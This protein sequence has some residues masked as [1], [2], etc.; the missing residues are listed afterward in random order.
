ML[1]KREKKLMDAILHNSN[2]F[3]AHEKIESVLASCRTSEHV[4]SVVNM[5][6]TFD[7]RFGVSGNKVACGTLI[8]SLHRKIEKKRKVIVEAE[9]FDI[10]E[11]P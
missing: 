3:E 10:I 1:S 4:E 9:N 6:K 5:L 7:E 11:K 8:I 2:M